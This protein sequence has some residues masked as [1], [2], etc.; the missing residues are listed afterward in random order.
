MQL[1]NR[2][3]FVNIR[4]HQLIRLSSVS[5]ENHTIA[6]KENYRVPITCKG[7]IDSALIFVRHNK[8]MSEEN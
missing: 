7:A 6:G 1:N 4:H 2:L 5:K 8:R 3:V